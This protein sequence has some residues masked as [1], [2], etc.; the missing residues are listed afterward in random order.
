MFPLSRRVGIEC[1]EGRV[2]VGNPE[3][4][5]RK[6]TTLVSG[7]AR[8]LQIVAD[9]DGTLTRQ[10]PR[11]PTDKLMSSFGS[12]SPFTYFYINVQQYYYLFIIY[13]C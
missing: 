6:L 9:F 11:L 10:R 3:L 13:N 7:G 1:V 8:R 5:E 12:Y 4:L 2:R